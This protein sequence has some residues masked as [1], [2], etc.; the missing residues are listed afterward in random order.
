MADD[1][2]RISRQ[3]D[4]AFEEVAKLSGSAVPPSDFFQ[5]FLAKV[6]A[7]IGAPAG[8]VWLRTPQGFLQ[9]QCQ[10]NIDQV[11]LDNQ[12]N[13]R[14]SHN[15][16]LR[17]AFQSVRPMLLE[18]MSSTGVMEGQGL[19][20]GNPTNMVT[21]LAPVLEDDKKPV[22]LVEVWQDPS[23]DARVQRTFLNYLVQMAGYAS[24][25]LRNLQ[26]RQNV[27][28]EQVW[29]QLES[30]AC[31]VHGS[32]NVT[33]VAYQVVNEGRRLIGCDRLSVACRET[34][35]SKAKIEA[36]SGADVVEKRS[37]LVRLMRT[38]ADKVLNWG[39]KLIYRGVKEEGLPPAVM[40][41]LDDYL[42]ESNSKLLVVLPLFDER[43]K[44]RDPA[45]KLREPEPTKP[46][47]SAL[48][49]ECFEPPA[50]TEPLIAR[51]EVIAR[52]SNSALYNAIELRRV[53]LRWL[54]KPVAAVQDGLGGKARTITIAVCTIL[55]IL[56]GAMILVPYPLKLEAKGSLMPRERQAIYATTEGQVVQLQVGPGSIVGANKPL[57]ILEDQALA[58][59][60]ETLTAQRDAAAILLTNLEGGQV[61]ANTPQ[62]QRDQHTAEIAKTRATMKS[63]EN[64]LRELKDKN[65]VIDGPRRGMYAVMSPSFDVAA[66]TVLRGQNPQ[67]T[68]LDP[69]GF[70]EALRNKHV[71]RS[72]PLLRLGNRNGTWEIQLKIPQKHIGQV[73]QAFP[74]NNP[75][76]ELEVDLLVASDP[77]H[78]Y[79]GRLAR[80]DV[81]YDAT[82]DKD[83][84]NESEP[85]VVSYVRVSGEGIP[86]GDAIPENLLLSGVEVRTRIRCGN[87]AMGYSLFYG[88]WD[89]LYEKMFQLF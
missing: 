31:N 56:T 52:H 35:K 5:A 78:T 62:T 79:K 63:Y 9:L 12:P 36:V 21:L 41:A 68:V 38:L 30:F 2:K 55:A 1:F 42:A 28:Q 47:R 14:Q 58:K 11:G 49:M 80:K 25:Y 24:N 20:A 34:R 57:L 13:G 73:L 64:Q 84:H 40:E 51:L 46:P 16:L 8:A 50:A 53:P 86:P 61:P 85:V 89:F 45:N 4:Q 60:L 54:W 43:D 71:R 67:W 19:P 3:I 26:G 87:H 76:A 10:A 48:I 70:E 82:P 72:E 23:F 65:H 37:T 74:P 27:N 88:V 66:N 29:S 77:N 69:P 32:L 22:G 17:Q 33:E 18:P 83:E 75:N 44:P 39:E 7:G 81:A 15:E 6:L 59:E